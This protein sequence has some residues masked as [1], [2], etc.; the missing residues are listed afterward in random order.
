M[1]VEHGR[2]ARQAIDVGV[3]VPADLQLEIAV[4]V[5]RDNL[6]QTLRQAVVD[7]LAFRLGARERIDQADGVARVNRCGRLRLASSLSKSNPARSVAVAALEPEPVR[8]HERE[9]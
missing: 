2:D 9:Y 5:S 8:F 6:F 7:A 4:A 3:D 1:R